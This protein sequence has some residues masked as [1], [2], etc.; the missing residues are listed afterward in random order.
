MSNL[1]LW[2]TSTVPRMNSRN[3]GSTVLIVGAS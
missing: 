1:A 2:A 3:D